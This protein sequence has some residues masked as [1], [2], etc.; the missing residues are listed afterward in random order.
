[1][2]LFKGFSMWKDLTYPLVGQYLF[3]NGQEFSLALYQL[4]TIRLWNKATPVN[5]LCYITV[6]ERLL[7]P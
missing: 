5:N 7:S 6:P 3:S 2:I 1:M 4:N